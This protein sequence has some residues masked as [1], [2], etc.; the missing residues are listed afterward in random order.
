MNYSNYVSC[1]TDVIF[2]VGGGQTTNYNIGK[3]SGVDNINVFR[4][5]G[6]VVVTFSDDSHIEYPYHRLI[7]AHYKAEEIN[8]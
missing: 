1:P 6:Y 5:D 7:S 2:D 4:E 8:L 3:H